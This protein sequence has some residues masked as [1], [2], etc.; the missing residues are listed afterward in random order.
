MSEAENKLDNVNDTLNTDDPADNGGKCKRRL[1]GGH[2]ALIVIGALLVLILAAVLTVTLIYHKYLNKINYTHDPYDPFDTAEIPID[3]LPPEY[4]ETPEGSELPTTI[5]ITPPAPGTTD[6]AYT[7]DPGATPVPGTPT[8]PP[9]PTPTPEPTEEP[10]EA[11]LLMSDQVYNILIIGSDSRDL[12]TFRG[13]SDVMIIL[14]VN[15]VTKRVWITS[16]QRDTYLH[17]P[18]VGYNKLNCAYAYS[19]AK[20]LQRT[21]QENYSIVAPNYVIVTFDGFRDVVNKIG[22]VE[23]EITDKEA[24]YISGIDSAGKYNLTG[25]QALAYARIRYID[26]DFAR[27]QRQR[28]VL[29]AVIE[30]LKKQSV[31][32]LLKTMDVLLP[33]L[34]TNIPRSEISSLI[35]KVPEYAKYPVSQLRIPIDGTWKYDYLP[36]ITHIVRVKSFWKN[37]LALKDNIYAG[38]FDEG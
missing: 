4:F 36:K 33:L 19:G 29:S 9:T 21:L 26:S 38:I 25:T 28:N 8:V 1:K 32:E 10:Y 30:K 37:Y 27:T 17:V 13:N 22:G 6:P 20:L 12:S 3:S 31:S 16:F 2:I 34:T 14:S 5:V 18:G 11:P 15:K 24:K 7:A 35:A 23:L